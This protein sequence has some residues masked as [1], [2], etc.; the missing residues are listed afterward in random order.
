[1]ELITPKKLEKSKTLTREQAKL[2][3][4]QLR[5]GKKEDREKGIFLVEVVFSILLRGKIK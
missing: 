5:E 3:L 4:Q 2:I 1:M